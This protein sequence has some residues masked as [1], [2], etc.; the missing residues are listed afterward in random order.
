MAAQNGHVGLVRMLVAKGCDVDA[1]NNGGQ[2]A[3]HMAVAYDYFWTAQVLVACGADP[4]LA[5]E[6]GHAAGAGIDGDKALRDPLAAFTD[7]Q[8]RPQLLVAVAMVDAGR[9]AAVPALDRSEFAMAFM[10]KRKQEGMP[11]LFDAALMGACR[12]VIA[13][14]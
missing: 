1:R 11:A 2:T 7:A 13:E 10:Q 4:A 6:D 14:W 5:N 9:R 3:L 8:T 12:R